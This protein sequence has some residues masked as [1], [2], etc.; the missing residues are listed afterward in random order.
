MNKT[1]P[2]LFSF[3]PASTVIPPALPTP[4]EK[5]RKRLLSQNEIV[6]L[7]LKYLSYLNV[8]ESFESKGQ[9]YRIRLQNGV[10]PR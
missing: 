7:G 1:I 2:N 3:L 6:Q 8:E 10:H 5:I 4:W 9:T